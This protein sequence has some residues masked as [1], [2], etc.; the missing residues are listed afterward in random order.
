MTQLDHTSDTV[1]PALGALRET[2]DELRATVPVARP[3][4]GELSRMA[5]ATTPAA[6]LAATLL[7]SLHDQGAVEGVQRF[8][9]Y[10]VA[11]T[12]RFDQVSHILGA[13]PVLGACAL[14]STT[15]SAGCSGNFDGAPR[16][17]TAPTAPRRTAPQPA[18]KP[19]RRTPTV[20][21]APVAP[22]PAAAPER[23]HLPQVKLPPLPGG[24]DQ[25]VNKV[26]TDVN[27]LLDFLLK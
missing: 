22:A 21:P 12:A 18:H 17:R 5:R 8:L 15:P 11:A 9:Y 14:Y 2:A 10:A 23:P 6:G 3:V 19:H 24:V 1:Q 7:K 20:A 16:A 4:I 27:D 25:V 13:Y 26:Q